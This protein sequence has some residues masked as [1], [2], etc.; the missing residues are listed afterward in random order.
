MCVNTRGIKC[1]NKRDVMY[2][3]AVYSLLLTLVTAW[4]VS[5]QAVCNALI[6]EMTHPSVNDLRSGSA[7][8]V[9]IMIRGTVDEISCK[10]S[11]THHR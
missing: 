9:R 1:W 4:A 7:V 6:C 11:G 2:E 10:Q 3:S 5:C 8:Q